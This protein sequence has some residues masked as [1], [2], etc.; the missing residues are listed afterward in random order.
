ME[1]APRFFIDLALR[2]RVERIAHPGPWTGD[3][4]KLVEIC[5]ILSSN[6]IILPLDKEKRLVQ[7]YKKHSDQSCN[8][9]SRSIKQRKVEEA[10]MLTVRERAKNSAKFKSN[11][12][13][14]CTS[15]RRNS[16]TFAL[17]KTINFPILPFSVSLSKAVSSFVKCGYYNYFLCR[18]VWRI[19]RHEAL[20]KVW[21]IVHRQMLVLPSISLK[22]KF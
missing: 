14:P 3:S 21:E 12:R 15:S 22:L 20:D 16:M 9:A 5:D 19:S 4:S 10:A 11:V 7:N 8:V 6:L 17:R 2:S 13:D 18:T 1:N